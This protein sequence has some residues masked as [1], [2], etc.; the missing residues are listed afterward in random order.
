MERLLVFLIVF[1]TISGLTILLLRVISAKVKAIQKVKMYLG[2][3]VSAKSAGVGLSLITLI[4][5]II[6]YISNYDYAVVCSIIF[7]I[8]FGAMYFIFKNESQ[9]KSPK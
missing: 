1:C 6:M 2:N 4:I 5:A 3:K 9:T 8:F 7:G